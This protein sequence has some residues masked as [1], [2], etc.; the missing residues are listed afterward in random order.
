MAYNLQ[1]PLEIRCNP[2][3]KDIPSPIGR[4]KEVLPATWYAP[5][6]R[7]QK[8]DQDCNKH[9]GAVITGH[10]LRGA[11]CRSMSCNSSKL[12]ISCWKPG[13]TFVCKN[14]SVIP[15]SCNAIVVFFRG[16]DLHPAQRGTKRT[17]RHTL[18]FFNF[19]IPMFDEEVTLA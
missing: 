1:F 8:M 11:S 12:L 14:M 16:L 19:G 9:T 5:Q 4:P 17:T 18:Q 2:R 7:E 15:T 6:E 10:L 13:A 3:S